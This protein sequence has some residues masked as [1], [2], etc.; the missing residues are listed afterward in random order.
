MTP[1]VDSELVQ[2]LVEAQR[3]GNQ[4]TPVDPEKFA[5]I[6]LEDGYRISLAQKEALN[7]TVGMYKTLIMADGVGAAGPIFASRIGH[8]PDYK[9]PAGL[10]VKGLE[11]EVGLEL[12][13]DVAPDENL[14]EEAFD[15]AVSHYFL[16][17][18]VVG[19][20]LAP[21]ATGEKPSMPVQLADH[22]SALGYVIGAMCPKDIDVSGGLTV[23]FELDGKEIHRQVGIQPN[24]SVVASALAHAA[25]G[26]D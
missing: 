14:D 25:Q 23:T 5:W 3:N 9:F 7:E 17:I 21:T 26:R 10:S 15:E 18:E 4:A 13:R 6:S 1:T 16:G 2:L 12:A 20:R 11:F 19:T 24:G 22:F 8:S